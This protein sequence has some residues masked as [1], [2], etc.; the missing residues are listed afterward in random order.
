MLPSRYQTLLT[1]LSDF[2]S[3]YY[4][5]ARVLS[6]LSEGTLLEISQSYLELLETVLATSLDHIPVFSR[7]MFRVFELREDQLRYVEA[8]A[9]DQD[10]W[11][12]QLP[13]FA[14]ARMLMNKLLLPTK[15]LRDGGGFFT[16]SPNTLALRYPPYL[17]TAFATTRRTV[18]APMVFDDPASRPWLETLKA[19]DLFKLTP[20]GG[21]AS[22]TVITG[23]E[24]ARLWL[25]GVPSNVPVSASFNVK[26]LRKPYDHVQSSAVPAAYATWFSGGYAVATVAGTKRLELSTSVHWQG[27]W[28]ASTAY[29]V[30]DI[31]TQAGAP[32][33]AL[34]AH[35]SG[36]VF[37]ATIWQP[38]VGSY[39]HVRQSTAPAN[40]GLSRIQSFVAPSRIQLQ[41]VD[42]FTLT[43]SCEVSFGALGGE[44]VAGDKPSW[45]LPHTDLDER[46]SVDI[47]AVRAH[48][49]VFDGVTYVAGGALLQGVDYA[50]DYV[51]GRVEQQTLWNVSSVARAAY[52]WFVS[53][54]ERT[55]RARGA[56]MTATAYLVGDV[57]TN[58]GKTWVCTVAHT[59]G[60]SLDTT[61]FVLYGVPFA[62]DVQRSVLA[63]SVWAADALEDKDD[64]YDTFGSLMGYRRPSSEAYRAFLRGVSQLFLLGP[65]LPRIEAALNAMAA[66]PT[67]RDDGEVLVS[68]SSGFVAGGTDG[69]LIG[70]REGTEDGTLVNSTARFSSPNA[71]FFANDV[72]A[73]LECRLGAG[74]TSFIVTSVVDVNTVV[75]SPAPPDAIVT[76]RYRHAVQQNRLR[77][78]GGAFAFEA[79]HVGALLRLTDPTAARNNGLFRVLSVD[80]AVTVTL[81]AS[82][83]F[84]DA[85]DVTWALANVEEQTVR[86]TARE[87]AFPLDTPMRADVIDPASVGVL[88]FRAFEALTSVFTVVDAVVDPTW[89]H[90]VRIPEEILQQDPERSA[91][92]YAS[93]ELIEHVYGALDEAALGDL[94]LIY[95]ADD[96]GSPGL[97]RDATATWFGGSTVVL[98]FAVDAPKARSADVGCYLQLQLGSINAPFQIEAVD[99]TGTILTLRNFPPPGLV[100]AIA[101][102][103]SLAPVIL[104][105]SVGFIM[106]DRAL[107]LHALNVR[108]APGVYLP[109]NFAADLFRLLGESKP[110]HVFLWLEADTVFKDTLVLRDTMAHTPQF[111]GNARMLIPDTILRYG[112]PV[113]YGDAFRYTVLTQSIVTNAVGT[114]AITVPHPTGDVQSTLVAAGF[115]PS[116]LAAGGLRAVSE[117]TDYAVDYQNKTITILAP[118]AATPNDLQV[119][120][121]IRRI[122]A[123]GDPLD[124]GETRLAYGGSN[125]TLIRAA[126]HG[127]HD[128]GLI[129]RAV[130]ITILPP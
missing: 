92:R 5:D 46:E 7:K 51:T 101:G 110:S 112:D 82:S 16:P 56:W 38:L 55:F 57:V 73:I 11:A 106:M 108:V 104:R 130:T 89:W 119:V 19:G 42:S 60:G 3:V 77:L 37:D 27:A 114:T 91:R 50:V 126:G 111:E 8:A 14:G 125:P 4:K 74:W 71:Y 13:G 24:A 123:P 35:T 95:G 70:G 58:A 96:N 97:S 2:W 49:V 29:A 28:A 59:S 100:P 34:Y 85:S 54:E 65:E 26:V 99:A 79:E 66:L 44:Y 75:I 48:S 117:G 9:L 78:T 63:A 15:V 10:Y 115:A 116:V 93:P 118:F 30:G 94:G 105:R 98:A 41:R 43:G 23:V 72:G 76:W 120:A 17:D 109:D 31:V 128:F 122:R 69:L 102:T 86:T 107:K 62:Y 67:V 45:L 83:G 47:H 33:V 20:T 22:Y 18:V 84:T 121:C 40:D 81:D 12:V 129:D 25:D 39:A 53:Y 80:D 124:A 36:L 6:A 32:Y 127:P 64:L 88:T 113:R 1:A 52:K 90:R 68:Y 21:E 103:A 87:Y 61:K